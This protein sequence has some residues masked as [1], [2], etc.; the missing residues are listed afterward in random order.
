MHKACK[1]SFTSEKE[2]TKLTYSGLEQKSIYLYYKVKCTRCG[3]NPNSV[4]LL[5]NQPL[6]SNFESRK[7]R[8]MP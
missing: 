8:T 2:K 1:Y 7:R 6:C 3:L 5:K 4:V